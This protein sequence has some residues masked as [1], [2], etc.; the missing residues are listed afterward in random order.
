MQMEDSEGYCWCQVPT[1]FAKVN[2]TFDNYCMASA[3]PVPPL[4]ARAVAPRIAVYASEDVQRLCQSLGQ[5]GGFGG[6]GSL[7]QQ[8]QDTL[9]RSTL[10]T[11]LVHR[12]LLN[13]IEVTV[14]TSTYES[15]TLTSFPLLID[16]H[17]AFGTTTSDRDQDEVALDEI[18]AYI[19]EN[20]EKWT[21]ETPLL[22]VRVDPGVKKDEEDEE[23]SVSEGSRKG[24]TVERDEGWS[25]S[26][27]I[28]E[29][30]GSNR[31]AQTSWA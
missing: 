15:Q 31:I 19:Q 24:K 14:R 4:V 30:M 12:L 8:F 17:S 16:D 1:H 11:F 2:L 27:F 9:E 28:F 23:E 18:G 5:D 13:Y 21:D 10:K 26:E 25:G 29:S 3:V 6:L 20:S 7:L 22:E